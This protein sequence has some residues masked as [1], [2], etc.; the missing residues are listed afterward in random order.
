[1]DS[2]KRLAVASTIL[3]RNISWIA[4]AEGKAGF[5]VAIDTAMLAGLATAYAD[6]EGIGCLTT[7]LVVLTAWTTAVSVVFAGLVVRPRTDGPERSL[8]FFGRIAEMTRQDY[9]ASLTSATDQE[10]LKDLA[11]QIHRNAEIAIEKHSWSR[12][13]ISA[14][15]LAG[16]L[17]IASIALLVGGW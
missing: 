6:A 10:L 15:F 12:R 17:W 9:G 2:G 16:I 13:S 7:I 11:D 14:A 3:D 5:A 4:A 1:M 8:F